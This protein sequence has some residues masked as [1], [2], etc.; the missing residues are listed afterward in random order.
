MATIRLTD[1]TLDFPIYGAQRSLRRQ[2]FSAATGGLIVHKGRSD[3]RVTV[4]AL[5]RLN[6]SIEHGDR[7]GLVG[8]NGAGKSTLLRVLAGVYAPTSGSIMV[9]G[10]VSPLFSA[11][12][13]IDYDATGY[14]NLITCGMF[15]GMSRKEIESKVKDIE[16]FCELGEYLALP[17]R[18]YST[19]MVTRFAFALA[20]T[21]DPGILLLDE[22]IAAGDARFAERASKRIEALIGRSDILV[23]ASH[24]DAMIR[25]M[26]NKA[27]LLTQGRM[28]TVGPVDEVYEVY[29]EYVASGGALPDSL[30]RLATVAA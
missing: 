8:H 9:D 15:L 10:R 22:G 25:S 6:L 14:E 1:L 3:S 16:D 4:R 27:I 26:C 20:T 28:V 30:P 21:I 19:G 29:A 23:L 5:D 17:M 12:P 11:S 13:G 2:L 18:T 24:S 7:L